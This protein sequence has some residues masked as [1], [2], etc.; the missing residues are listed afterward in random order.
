LP[1]HLE[2][3]RTDQSVRGLS[4]ECSVST[5][6]VGGSRRIDE[7]ASGGRRE[8]ILD[9][10]T[11]LFAEFGFNDADT[12][13]LAERLGVGKGTVYRCFPSKRDLFLASVDRVIGL[14]H[15]CIEHSCAGVSDPLEIV[16][17][18]IRAYLDFFSNH[19]EYVEL[20]IQ[21]RALFRDRKT[22]TYFEHRDRHADRWRDLYRE[23]IAAGRVRVIAVDRIR[24]VINQLLY[25]TI[26]TNYF[27]GQRKTSEE[28]TKEIIDIVFHGILCEDERSR[29]SF[30]CPETPLTIAN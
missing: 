29:G 23:L 18:G 11:S 9:A 5:E 21:E 30:D 28:Q 17:R 26:F 6:D 22:P 25:G 4:R 2:S 15:E 16:V 1:I 13:E 19:P 20:I 10:A 14:L 12:Q 24:D 3:S 27:G 8:A 7:K